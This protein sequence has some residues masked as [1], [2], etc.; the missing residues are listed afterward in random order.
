MKRRRS[1]FFHSG[2]RGNAVPVY[3]LFNSGAYG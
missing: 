2:G 1:M 3:L